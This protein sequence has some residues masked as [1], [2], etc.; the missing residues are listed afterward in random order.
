MLTRGQFFIV[1]KERA[2]REREG[3][4]RDSL[5]LKRGETERERD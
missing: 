3:G 5:L 4:E 2:V 1:S